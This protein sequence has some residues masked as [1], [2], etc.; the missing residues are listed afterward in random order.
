MPRTIYHASARMSL[1][2]LLV[3][4][5]ACRLQ[6]AFLILADAGA[7]GR[8]SDGEALVKCVSAII[9]AWKIDGEP[10]C[11]KLHSSLVVLMQMPDGR[12][13]NNDPA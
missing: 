5:V 12:R 9:Q 3:D 8:V 6:L 2:S 10:M 11:L 1:F 7:T 4:L 13:N